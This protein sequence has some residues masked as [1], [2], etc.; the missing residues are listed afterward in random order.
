MART[1]ARRAGVCAV[2]VVLSVA[3]RA[4]AWRLPEA[5]AV[6]RISE[7][8]VVCFRFQIPDSTDIFELSRLARAAGVEA[9]VVVLKLCVFD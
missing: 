1:G 4:V 5:K 9:V 6:C 8:C 2:S 3:L 7:K